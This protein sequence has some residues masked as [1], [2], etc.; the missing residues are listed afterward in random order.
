MIRALGFYSSL[1]YFCKMRRSLT[2]LPKWKRMPQYSLRSGEQRPLMAQLLYQSGSFGIAVGAIGCVCL[3]VNEYLSTESKSTFFILI[4]L[5]LRHENVSRWYVLLSITV[6]CLFKL[7]WIFGNWKKRKFPEHSP[8][9]LGFVHVVRGGIY[10][11]LSVPVRYK[12]PI[13][14]LWNLSN[15]LCCLELK[16]KGMWQ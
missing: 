14:G 7:K 13:W 2:M 8:K 1:G 12:W 5:K 9:W 15:H 6:I 16:E 4:L 10:I 11:S 3:Y